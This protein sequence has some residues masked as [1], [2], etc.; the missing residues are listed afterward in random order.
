MHQLIGASTV[1]ASFSSTL[2]LGFA[3]LSLMLAA[4]GL[5]GVLGYLAAQRTSEIGVRIALGAQPNQVLRLMLLDGLRP[6]GIGLA[7][8][9]LGGLLASRLIRTMLYHVRP[10]DA[11]VYVSVAAVLMCVAAVSC[12][13]PAWRASRMDPMHALRVE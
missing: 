7:F 9:L 3:I 11:S 5:Y 1:Q 2:I 13:L 12:L 10:L 6:A 8:G 4:V